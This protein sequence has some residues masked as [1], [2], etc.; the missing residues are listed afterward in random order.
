MHNSRDPCLER[1]CLTGVPLYQKLRNYFTLSNAMRHP[2]SIAHHLV[3]IGNGLV[4]AGGDLIAGGRTNVK[5][6]TH[7]SGGSLA[8][9]LRISGQIMFL[10]S[11]FL[12]LYGMFRVIRE[13]Q[14]ERNGHIH[15]TLLILLATWPLL[16]IRCVYGILSAT[17][18]AFDYFDSGNYANG[19][20]KTDFVVNENV[21][22]TTME[23]ATSVLLM[24]TWFTSR[25][26]PS[27]T[28]LKEGWVE[29]QLVIMK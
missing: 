27:M 2:I 6:F 11:V 23:W 7:N 26:G 10:I 22:G 5:D 21:L 3:V 12:L 16:L 8:K 17:V 13:C 25:R 19:G 24:L 14:S 29:G 1:K 9:G 20:L 15:P 28:E 4:I 18:P